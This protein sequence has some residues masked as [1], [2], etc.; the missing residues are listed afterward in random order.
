MVVFSL[1]FPLSIHFHFIFCSTQIGNCR[2][3]YW[4]CFRFSPKHAQNIAFSFC[5]K[6]KRMS[7]NLSVF[8][9]LFQKKSIS[10]W[11]SWLAYQFVALSTNQLKC[12]MYVWTS[13]DDTWLNLLFAFVDGFV[14]LRTN[15]QM[16]KLESLNSVCRTEKFLCSSLNF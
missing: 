6:F 3:F 4:N 1:I 13:V 8:F 2:W 11:S 16:P 9:C 15:Q 10:V 12:M 14:F 7:Q 5:W